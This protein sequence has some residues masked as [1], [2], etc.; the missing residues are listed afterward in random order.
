LFYV[1]I[2]VGYLQIIGECVLMVLKNS[3]LT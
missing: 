2:S 3:S 1:K